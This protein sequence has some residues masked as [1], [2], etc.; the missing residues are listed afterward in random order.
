MKKT[1]II[2]CI[3][4]VIIAVVLY[5]MNLFTTNLSEAGLLRNKIISAVGVIVAIIAGGA[6]LFGSSSGDNDSKG[7]KKL[8]WTVD[9][10]C[11]KFVG[12][13]DTRTRTIFA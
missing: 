12:L 4:L 8:F 5:F 2:I 3:I 10:L 13:T 11:L 9:V 7:D 6:H 1:I